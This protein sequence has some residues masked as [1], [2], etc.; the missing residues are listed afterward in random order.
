MKQKYTHDIICIGAGSGGLNIAGFMVKAG[1]KVLLI[2]KSDENI[3][4]DCLNYG[5]VP[6][7]ALIHIAR[8]AKSTK[9]STKFGLKTTGQIDIKKVM[10]YVKEKKDIIRVHENA[11]YFKKKGMDVALGKA[12]LV[13]KNQVRVNN[14]F[15][16]AKKIILATGSRPRQLKIPG[17]DK[18]NI[19][20]NET[21]FDIDKLPKHLV[22][23]GAGPI[24]AELG[25]AFANLGSK[26]TLLNRS[27][28]FLKKEDQEIAKIL[29]TKLEQDGVQ[30]LENAKPVEFSS[31]TQL[32]IEH[33]KVKKKITFD[34]IL[35]SIGRDLNI[36]NLGLEKAG[37]QLN[38]TGRKLI[39]DDYLRTTNK[40]VLVCGDIAG[41]YQF[42][43]AAELHAA[44]IITNFFSPFKKKVNYD[45]LSWVTYTSPEIA[46]FGLNEEQLKK[47]KIK[48][49]KLELDF[50]DDDRA[51]VDETT[52]GKSILYVSKSDKLLGGTMVAN[53]A[54][55]LF[56]ELV[57]ANSAGLD[58]ND[59][60]AKVYPYPTAS[61]VNKSIVAK[62]FQNKLNAKSKK[63]LK[64]LY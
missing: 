34:A 52:N 18:V 1:F 60:F 17:S 58:L 3:G 21:I 31:P 63:I 56:Q 2:D 64:W 62:A 20:T 36:E 32:I 42:T 11:A 23:V 37:I 14:T 57:L 50:T 39:V 8:Q 10:Q 13:S 6:S 41:S 53:N 27:D 9:D 38:E 28:I 51:I 54:G 55:E 49:T 45:N 12:T 35:S 59:I 16:S 24:G 44:V 46:T 25:Q 7:K 30:I 26:V 15:Y 40:N 5:C 4:G 43:H 29:Q 19:L 33:N 48:Y 47:R 22:I 61:R